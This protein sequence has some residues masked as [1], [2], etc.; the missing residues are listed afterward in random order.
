MTEPWELNSDQTPAEELLPEPV[1]SKF[2][3][4]MEYFRSKPIGSLISDPYDSVL[5]A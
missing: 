1:I 4:N 5:M 3:F 2:P